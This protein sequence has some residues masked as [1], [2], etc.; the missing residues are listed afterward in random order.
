MTDASSRSASR[1][2]AVAVSLV[3]TIAGLPAVPGFPPA[4]AV[5]GV[6]AP[7]SPPCG[8]DPLAPPSFERTLVTGIRAEATVAAAIAGGG[9]PKVLGR[10]A[11]VLRRVGALVRA[12]LTAALRG[13][14]DRARARLERAAGRLAKLEVLIAGA[15][16]AALI[17]QPAAAVLGL[18]Q[19]NLAFDVLG[20]CPLPTGCAPL[21]PSQPCTGTGC[22]GFEVCPAQQF[23]TT[24]PFS[25]CDCVV[26]GGPT[27]AAVEGRCGSG[28]G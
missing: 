11:T 12:A 16:A 6:P 4:T 27:A 19:A 22:V 25:N 18:L 10:I 23:C 5:A 3:L 21:P 28:P 17:P 26:F 2:R 20:I 24:D 15:E 14:D 8:C 1:R 9:D 13:R 7:P